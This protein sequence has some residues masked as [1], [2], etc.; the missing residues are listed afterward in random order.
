LNDSLGKGAIRLRR[1]LVIAGTASGAGK[2]A[3]AIGIMAAL[4][5]RGLKVAPFKVGPDYID[6]G[7]HQ[8]ATGRAPRNLDTWLRDDAGMRENFLRGAAEADVSIIEG[9]MGLFD[10]RAGAGNAGSTAEAAVLLEEI[11]RAHV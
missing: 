1:P 8:A 11:G 7:Y 2:T 4:T 6:P 10:G 9:V 5:R 3:V